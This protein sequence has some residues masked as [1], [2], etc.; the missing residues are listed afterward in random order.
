MWRLK[1][2]VMGAL[3]AVLQASANLA[4]AAD[5][6]LLPPPFVHLRSIDPSIAQDLRYARGD[7]FTGK[8]LPGY[9]AAEC[10]LTRQT[11][12]ALARAQSTLRRTNPELTLKV[13]DCYRPVRAVDAMK[14]WVQQTGDDVLAYHHPRLSRRSL[15]AQG[16]IA[17]RSGHSRGHTIDVT[18]AFAAGAGSGD[19]AVA[20]RGRL[21][22]CAG[23]ASARERDGSLDMGTSFDCFDPRAHTQA[24]GLERAAIVSRR[25]LV[26]L[27]A[28]HGFRNYAREWWHFTY[29][30]GDAGKAFDFPIQPFVVR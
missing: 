29:D 26:D 3:V 17:A 9:E 11:A 18:L 30:P 8:T 13:Y 6:A 25:E 1:F 28:A 7:N 22:D 23:P 2:M 24:A 19:S 14:N 10:I 21:T 4:M 15:V 16:Y 20:T 27:L 12:L 5:S